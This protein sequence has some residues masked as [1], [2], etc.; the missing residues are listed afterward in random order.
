MARG[1]R[2]IGVVTWQAFLVVLD[3]VHGSRT[4]DADASD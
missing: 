4:I 3:A 2:E 1:P